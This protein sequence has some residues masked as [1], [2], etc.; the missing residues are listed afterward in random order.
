[1]SW[2]AG[3]LLSLTHARFGAGFAKQKWISILQD[4]IFRPA[5]TLLTALLLT[6]LIL[7]DIIFRP[8]QTPCAKIRQTQEDSRLRVFIHLA[9]SLSMDSK[10][11]TD[12]FQ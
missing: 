12:A 3:T 9:L 2:G 5:Q 4:I 7:Q 1:M 11:L 8:A 10:L 6:A